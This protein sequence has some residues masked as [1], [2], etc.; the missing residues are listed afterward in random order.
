MAST[1]ESIDSRSEPESTDLVTPEEAKR[2]R[3]KVG[4]CY[5]ICCFI[6]GTTWYT[7]RVSVEPGDGYPPLFAGA[8]RFLIAIILYTPLLLIFRKKLGTVTRQEFMW[9]C[10]SGFFN[11]G[12]QCFIYNAEM[13]ISGGL[14]SVL[15][16]T[17]PLMVASVASLLGLEK[18]RR[19]TVIGFLVSLLGI[20]L[21]CH[22]RIQTANEQVV[23]IILTIVA[24]FFTSLSNITLKGRGTRVHPLTSATIFLIATDIPVWIASFVA[25]EKPHI[26]PLGEPFLAVLYMSIMSSIIAFLLYLYMLR[27]MSLM[28]IS[29]LQFIIPVLALV[30]DMFLEH[31]VTLNPQVWVGIAVVLAGVAFSMRRH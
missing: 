21:V 16:A 1:N 3:L 5:A 14:A 6:W 29:T 12:Y 8:F 27:H 4:I 19:N 11:G 9:I 13:T 26:F 23:G 15:M 24:A 31:R 30:I 17:A 25:G 7:V 10:L 20:G 18:V 2:T 22:D 28:A